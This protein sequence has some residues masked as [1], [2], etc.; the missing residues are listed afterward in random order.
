[1][2]IQIASE[3][4]FGCFTCAQKDNGITFPL[5][6]VSYQNSSGINENHQNNILAIATGSDDIIMPVATVVGCYAIA[7]LVPPCSPKL[8]LTNLKTKVR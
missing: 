2:D 5:Q 4:C 3:L 1:M 7:G 6:L 8:R